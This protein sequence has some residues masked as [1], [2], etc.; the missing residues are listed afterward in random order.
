MLTTTF[1]QHLQSKPQ[2]VVNRSLDF[3]SAATS[4]DQDL[5]SDDLD[6]PT[7]AIGEEESPGKSGAKTGS[8][9]IKKFQMEDEDEEDNKSNSASIQSARSSQDN[10]RTSHAES[11]RRAC[12]S[13]GK[14]RRRLDKGTLAAKLEA[15]L[16]QRDSDLALREHM[17]GDTSVEGIDHM[18][19]TVL[20]VEDD[21]FGRQ[22]AECSSLSDPE[23]HFRVLA[24]PSCSK[25]VRFSAG[26]EIRIRQPFCT[27]PAKDM[28]E[29][30]EAL[31]LGVKKMDV[32]N[33]PVLPKPIGASQ[34]HVQVLASWPV[35]DDV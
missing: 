9:W 6:E 33:S 1:S 19:L 17:R 3:G 18:D 4:Q 13:S 10:L 11:V 25:E 28:E 34:E 31:I 27:V 29:D 7:Q 16:R 35:P 12:L 24:H 32:L 22:V 26:C 21:G 23:R 5:F 14:K 20:S 30:D 8:S 2:K 15:A